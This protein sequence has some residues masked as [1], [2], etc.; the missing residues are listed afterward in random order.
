MGLCLKIE[1]ICS[2]GE[3]IYD[4]KGDGICFFLYFKRVFFFV[5]LGIVLLNFVG[6][7]VEEK[8]KFGELLDIKVVRV[9]FE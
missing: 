5:Y 1:R 7:R 3:I 2:I 9:L 8:V 4:W 6:E